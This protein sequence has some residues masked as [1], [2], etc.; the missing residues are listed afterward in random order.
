[1]LRVGYTANGRYAIARIYLGADAASCPADVDNSGAVDATDLAAVL[2]GWGTTSPDIDGDG[3]VN[4][5]DLAA[6]LAVWGSCN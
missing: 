1:M 2:A 6:L 4:A 5:A 3:S